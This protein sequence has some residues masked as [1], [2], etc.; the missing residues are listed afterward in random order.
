MASYEMI[1]GGEVKNF[2][3]SFIGFLMKCLRYMLAA[4]RNNM[5]LFI[6]ILLLG[7]VAGWFR[8]KDR[9][10]YYESTMVCSF[11]QL[12]KKTFGE[13]V[14]RLDQLAASHSYSRLATLLNITVEEAKTIV[15][16]DDKNVA[17]SPLHDDVTTEKLPLYF[18]LR[19]TDLKVF[20]AV[21]KG[22]LQYLNN[23]PYQQL[24]NDL[25]REKIQQRIA[26][27][28]AAD[29]R[30]DS[31]MSAYTTFLKTKGPAA[32]SASGF[33]GIISLF[34]YREELT[35]KKL[36]DQKASRLM[37]PVELLYGFAPSESP[38]NNT[39][40]ELVKLAMATLAFA[41]FCVVLKTVMANG[42]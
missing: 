33:S 4:V 24:R 14:F 7:S 16:F 29:A 19:T 34:R 36:N 9:Q 6:S 35:D 27:Y 25:D 10:N 40:N 30:I 18:T 12:H 28:N 41:L 17:G 11:N 23:L 5:L 38:V 32:D 21:E 26:Y 31:L 42:K 15:G 20:P 39:S 3:S 22:L 8:L 37:Q 2:L 13:M 1:T